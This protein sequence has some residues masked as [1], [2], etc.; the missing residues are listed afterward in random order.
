MSK[1]IGERHEIV[2]ETDEST[3]ILTADSRDGRLVIEQ[4]RKRGAGKGEE[5]SRGGGRSAP[6]LSGGRIDRGDRARTIARQR[7]FKCASSGSAPSH[8]RARNSSD[9]APS[10]QRRFT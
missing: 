3:F 6:A 1:A 5:V 9:R 8:A 7:Q 10:L 2:V 4:R